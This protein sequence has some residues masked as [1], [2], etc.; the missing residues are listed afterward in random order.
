MPT[1]GMVMLPG[2]GGAS[3]NSRWEARGSRAHPPVQRNV[4]EYWTAPAGPR[5][6]RRRAGDAF[7]PPARGEP[8][9][10]SALVRAGSDILIF[11]AGRKKIGPMM[12][13]T[14]SALLLAAAL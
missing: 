14:I 11:Q 6:G 1:A 3:D 8:Y 12:R 10:P 9:P 7:A 5:Q 2:A 13:L 4:P